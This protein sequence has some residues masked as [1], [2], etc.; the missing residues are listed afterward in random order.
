MTTPDTTPT[1]TPETVD[2]PIPDGTEA[3]VATA[4]M[5]DPRERELRRRKALLV[6]FLV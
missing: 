3:T 5:E 1:P 4:V 6:L 2:A